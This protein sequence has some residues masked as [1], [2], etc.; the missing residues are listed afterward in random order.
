MRAEAS[1][2]RLVKRSATRRTAGN[3]TQLAAENHRSGARASGVLVR[4]GWDERSRS[5]RV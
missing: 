4:V 1:S 5:I 3:F 2:P